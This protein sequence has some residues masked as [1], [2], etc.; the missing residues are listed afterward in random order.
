MPAYSK[1]SPTHTIGSNKLLL[2]SKNSVSTDYIT[3]SRYTIRQPNMNPNASA[4]VENAP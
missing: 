2:S 1:R 3:G 4:S